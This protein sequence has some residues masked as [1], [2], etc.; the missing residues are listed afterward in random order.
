MSVPTYNDIVKNI[1]EKCKGNSK[2]APFSGIVEHSACLKEAHVF[3]VNVKT[4]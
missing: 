2:F 3:P 4:D 1:I